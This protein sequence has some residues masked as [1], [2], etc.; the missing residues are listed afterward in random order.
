[1]PG[2]LFTEYFL[3]DG[4]KE[5]A[6]SRESVESAGEFDSFKDEVRQR[7]GAISGSSSPNEATTEQAIVHPALQLLGWADY[8]PQQGSTGNEDIPDHLLFADPESKERAGARSSARNRY[9]DALVVEESKRLG[10]SLDARETD[11]VRFGHVPDCSQG[12]REGVWDIQDKEDGAGAY[13][14]AIGR[15]YGGQSGSVGGKRLALVK[16]ATSPYYANAALRE[17]WL[18]DFQHV[19]KCS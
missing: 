4:I 16:R 5:S 7:Y 13:K 2:Q 9:R 15:G 8:L 18:F 3:T 10:L 19:P 12:G 11:G 6:E 14:R 17:I 1:M